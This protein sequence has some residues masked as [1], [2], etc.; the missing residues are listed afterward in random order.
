MNYLEIVLQGYFNDNSREYLEEYFLRAYKR[1]E[2]EQF[3]GADEFFNG[4]LNV[5]E[6][7]EACITNMVLK[8]K[9]ELQSALGAAE[10]GTLSYNDMEGKTIEQKNQETIEICKKELED[11]RPDGVGNLSFTIHLFSITNGRFDGHLTYDEILQIKL[12]IYKAFNKAQSKVE[13]PPPQPLKTKAEI[14][15]E[16]LSK[17]GFFELEKVKA[18]SEQSQFY[19]AEK[20]SE[21]GLPYA[22]AMFDYLKFIQYLEKQ[23]FNSKYKRNIEVSKWF[24]SDI[25]G[26]A[27]KGNISSLLKNT[28]ENKDR[29]TAYKHKENVIKDYELLK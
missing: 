13:T 7:F 6:G 17:Y 25:E 9:W 18:L 4:C 14:L 15:K 3:F 19:L 20:I 8:R 23:H 12:S 29:Y 24:N 26:R 10:R 28:T 22:I 1:A 21:N 16:K 11:I 27:V 2:S 5:I